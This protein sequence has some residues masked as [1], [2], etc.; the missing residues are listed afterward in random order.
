MLGKAS[1]DEEKSNN[2]GFSSEF[3]QLTVRESW[4]EIASTC[5]YN[6]FKGLR[7]LRV[8]LSPKGTICSTRVW[9]G[10]TGERFYHFPLSKSVLQTLSHGLVLFGGQQTRY[11]VVKDHVTSHE[12][13]RIQF[14]CFKPGEHT[15]RMGYQTQKIGLAAAL[16][17][18]SCSSKTQFIKSLPPWAFSTPAFGT[19]NKRQRGVSMES[20]MSYPQH[21][22]GWTHLKSS[23]EHQD[24]QKSLPWHSFQ[25]D[26]ANSKD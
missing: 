6:F 13:M 10:V 12:A 25:F 21:Q 8:Q 7:D 18:T 1:W 4:W 9:R 17:C 19:M 23:V 22:F 2:A 11:A 24:P 5:F 20:T 26:A 16:G 15:Q 3:K 14:C